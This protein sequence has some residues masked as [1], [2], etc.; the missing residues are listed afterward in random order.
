MLNT[1]QNIKYTYYEFLSELELIYSYEKVANFPVFNVKI[2]NCR[3][4][5][6]FDYGVNSDHYFIKQLEEFEESI[7][8]VYDKSYLKRFYKQWQPKTIGEVFGI[9][10]KNVDGY[11]NQELKNSFLLPWQTTS[12][13]TRS[14]GGWQYSGPTSC[15]MGREHFNRL[16]NVYASILKY[17]Y[18]PENNQNKFDTHIKGYFLK[19]SDEFKF[20]ITNG[21]HRMAVVSFLERSLNDMGQV[22]VTFRINNP[23]VI[24]IANVLEWP[25][26][27]NKNISKSDACLIFNKIFDGSTAV[28]RQV[29][30]L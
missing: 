8:I 20:I 24:D 14:V 13:I 15:K 17:G 6:G 29:R 4:P 28:T 23:R 27:H 7:N 18:K 2:N 30:P 16:K 21:T 9:S 25:Q 11:L 5:F 10:C 26:V 19:K 3:N 22:P 1:D 12:A